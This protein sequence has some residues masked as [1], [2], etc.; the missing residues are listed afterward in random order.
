MDHIDIRIMDFLQKDGRVSHSEIAKALDLSSPTVGE[1]IKKLENSGVIQRYTCILSPRKL[2]FNITAFI[3]VSLEKPV[4]GKAFVERILSCPEVLECFHM[5]G[6]H[7]Y[8]LKVRTSTP[9]ALEILIE[10]VI[11]QIE[12]VADTNTSIVLS[13]TKE[14]TRL[15]LEHL[16]ET[17]PK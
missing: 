16:G 12:G 6:A 14:T 11:R 15:S 17:V 5:T 1:R 3:G 8:L 10:N 7:D 4:Y 13:I 2:G 9:E